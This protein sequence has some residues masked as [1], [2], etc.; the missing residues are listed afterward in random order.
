MISLKKY[1]ESTAASSAL[2]H[3]RVDG[4]PFAI[5]LRAYASALL[6]MG[7]CSVDACPGL[8]LELKAQLT[9]IGGRL[10]KGISCET[11]VESDRE[12][13]ERLQEW[14]Q[15]TARHYQHKSDEVKDLLLVM[16][17][18]AESVGMR[19]QQCAGQFREVTTRLTAI[20]SLDDLTQI[21][22]SIEK[23][24]S[25][26]KS[27]I[28]RMTE[29]GTAA[30]DRLKEQVSTYRVKLEEAEAIAARDT[31]TGLRSRLNVESHI[32]RFIETGADF[33][34]A[35]VDID[36]FKKVN[37]EHGHLV[38]DEL[39]KQFATEMTA[40]CRSSDVIGRW[41]GD[42]F[43]IALECGLAEATSQIDRLRKWVCGNYTVPAQSG[44]QKLT[45]EASIGLAAHLANEPM[46]ELLCRADA[47]MYANKSVGHPSLANS[48]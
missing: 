26:L 14:G 13:R 1:L 15:L 10:T 41:G 48:K 8:G 5:A 38:G 7:G 36:S 31:L 21:R 44:T 24:A 34:V 43:I 22:A 35:I 28:D 4:D 40:A 27:S 39:L 9:R 11:L 2:D 42:E 33:C 6:A 29:E 3:K 32:E 25:D 30:I 20:A 17:Q 46:K 45:V 23:S 19:D 12:V 47:A 37:D 18:T 16:A